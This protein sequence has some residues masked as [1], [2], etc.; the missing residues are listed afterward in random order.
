MNYSDM[1]GERT[2]YIKRLLEITRSQLGSQ[3]DYEVLIEYSEEDA[4]KNPQ[5]LKNMDILAER[6]GTLSQT[7]ISNGKPRVS[8]VTKI[9]KEMK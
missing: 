4:I 6:I 5:V 1:M 3:Y 9:I 7:K 2:P 8:S